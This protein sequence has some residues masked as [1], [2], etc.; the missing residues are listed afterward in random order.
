MHR[1]ELK[2]LDN[3][4]WQSGVVVPNA[5]CGVESSTA[6]PFSRSGDWFLMH[7]VEL[8]ESLPRCISAISYKFL[9]HRVELKAY[10]QGKKAVSSEALPSS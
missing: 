8:K 6:S 10:S 4:Q 5:P 7:R 3:E 1:V 9:M 2:G